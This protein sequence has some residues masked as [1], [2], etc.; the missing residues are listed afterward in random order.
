MLYKVACR[1]WFLGS[2]G[3]NRKLMKFLKVTT[4]NF[5]S[6]LKMFMCTMYWQ[7]E[8]WTFW[9]VVDIYGWGRRAGCF[10]AHTQPKLLN[11]H[12]LQKVVFLG[13][14]SKFCRPSQ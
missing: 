10:A 8:R 1:Q 11:L 5:I 2:S 7:P 13:L 12:G 3:K 14:A 6:I 4:L 9:G